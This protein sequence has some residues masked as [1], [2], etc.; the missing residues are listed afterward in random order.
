MKKKW[1]LIIGASAL[2]LVLSKRG[3][4]FAAAVSSAKLNTN[5]FVEDSETE[6]VVIDGNWLFPKFLFFITQSDV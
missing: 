4:A 1:F 5:E 6:A 2:F 3:I